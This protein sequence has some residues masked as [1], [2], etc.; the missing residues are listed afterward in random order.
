[1]N[2]FK[3]FRLHLIERISSCLGNGKSLRPP[4]KLI[5][6]IAGGDYEA[7]GNEF[8]RYFV[9]IGGL[10]PDHRVLD[11][12]CG[13]GRMAVPLMKYLSE[14]GSYEGVDIVGVAID[15]CRRHIAAQDSRFHFQQADVFNKSYNPRGSHQPKEYQFPYPSGSFD[16]VFLTSVF[17]HMLSADMQHYLSEIARILKP[18]GRCMISMFLINPESQAL[19][20]AGQCVFRLTVPRQD[21][22]ILREKRPEEA[23]GYPEDFMRQ[24]YARNHLEIIEPVHF[25]SWVGRKKPL[26][27]QDIVLARKIG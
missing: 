9:E 16:F 18:D 15:W 17:T 6:A 25:G 20:D 4:Q 2:R 19:M 23:V 22:M 21:C 1:M 11:V 3:V 24:C 5:N 7:V 13:C 12:G 8:V 10:K 26:S 27:L 14:K